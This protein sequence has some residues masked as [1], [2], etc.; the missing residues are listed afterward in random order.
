MSKS[1]GNV[2]DPLDWMDEVRCRRV[3]VHPWPAAPV[4]AATWPSA[5]TTSARRATS[6]PSCS[7]PPGTRCSTVP[8]WRP[9]PPPDELTDADRWILGRLEEVRAEVDSAF[10]GY[11]FSRACEAL[12]HF[13]WDEF[14]DWYV[15]LAKAQLAQG[16]HA[17][18]RRAGRGAG[19]AAAVAAPGDPIRHRGVVA[20]FDERGDRLGTGPASLVIA[21]WPEALRYQPGSRCRAADQ[22]HAEAG[23]RGPPVPQ[24]SGSG[25][26]AEG[27][28][29]VGRRAGRRI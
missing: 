25:R 23:D 4:P 10:D 1:K 7:T 26:P 20:G 13:A 24:R 16:L 15:E 3:A 17:H 11:E 27:A 12:Y 22:R 29:A 19:H 28:G 9:L 5:R 18:H 21:D 6:A 8:P 2:I 14:C